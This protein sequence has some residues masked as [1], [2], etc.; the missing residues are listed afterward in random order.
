[1]VRVGISVCSLVLSIAC[2]PQ[3]DV[4]EGGVERTTSTSTSTASSLSLSGADVSSVTIVHTGDAIGT[5]VDPT[6]DTSG[7]IDECVDGVFDG[8]WYSFEGQS[9]VDCATGE[10]YLFEDRGLY[11]TPCPGGA[12]LRVEGTLCPTGFFEGPFHELVGTI[13]QGP[14]VAGCGEV[15]EPDACGTPD[16]VCGAPVCDIFAQ[17]CVLGERCRPSS[18]DGMPPWTTTIC[19]GEAAD[20]QPLGAPCTQQQLWNDDCA[21]GLFC[22]NGMCAAICDPDGRI[23]CPDLCT[24]CDTDPPLPGLGVCGARSC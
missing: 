12:W 20:P 9:F 4:G 11:G 19:V 14:C 5:S 18:L 8:L 24:F 22:A 17:D 15:P 6:N 10:S 21:A 23:D 16:E 3:V 1:M 2:G 13:V 7:T